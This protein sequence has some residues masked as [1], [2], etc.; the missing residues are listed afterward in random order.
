MTK[1]VMIEVVTATIM[2]VEEIER[3][4]A[5]D[6]EC[7]AKFHVVPALPIIFMFGRPIVITCAIAIALWQIVMDVSDKMLPKE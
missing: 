4:G 6:K 3:I 2:P 7:R 5:A 1:P